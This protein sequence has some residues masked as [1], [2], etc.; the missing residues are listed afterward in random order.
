M[1][2]DFIDVTCN[3]SFLKNV[4][5]VSRELKNQY[6]RHQKSYKLPYSAVL[7]VKEFNSTQAEHTSMPRARMHT[8]TWARLSAPCSCRDSV[9]EGVGVG[10]AVLLHELAEYGNTLP[11]LS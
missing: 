10:H 8:Q 3:I 6:Y 9:G 1:C 2:D 5:Q 7:Q 4:L 11:S